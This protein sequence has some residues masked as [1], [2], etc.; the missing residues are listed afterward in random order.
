MDLL[1][2][3]RMHEHMVLN[4][5]GA[6]MGSPLD[7]VVMPPRYRERRSRRFPPGSFQ[8]MTFWPWQRHLRQ[9][10]T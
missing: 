7:V 1:V 6:P 3:G 10:L 5:V 4:R 8:P 2:T 9:F